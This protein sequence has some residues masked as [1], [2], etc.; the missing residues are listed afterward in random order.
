MDKRATQMRK[1]VV[2]GNGMGG[3]AAVEAILKRD[4]NFSITV[5]GGERQPYYNR[6]LLSEVLSGQADLD[7]IIVHPL[8]WYADHGIDFRQGVS[9]ASI[10]PEGKTVRDQ[11]GNVIDYDALLLATGSRPAMPPIKGLQKK[12]V[13]TFWTV[14]DTHRIISAVCREREAV[15]I[16]G[17]L[18]G[19]EA[20][21]ALI[22][23][24]VSVT[25]VHLTD[26]LMDR[27]LDSAAAS[28]LKKQI[29]QL[30]IR[31]LLE[32]TAE[33][34]VGEGCV[35]G[36]RLRERGETI[37]TGMVLMTTGTRPNTRL[38]EAAGLRVNEG[39]VVDDRMET[40]AS[41]IYAIGDAI[42]HRGK[43][44][45]LVAP[46][47]E[48]AQVLSDVL[49]GGD[50]TR[51]EGS[52]CATILKVAGI[53]LSS[54]GEI[55]RE[56]GGEALAVLDTEK[57]IYKKAVIRQNRLRGYI[58]LGDQKEGPRLFNLMTKGEDIASIRDRLFDLI[59]NV[60]G[61]AESGKAAPA[62]SAAA[63]LSDDD[64]V[65]NCNNVSK[66]TIASAIRE[67]KLKTR[68]AVARCTE[69]T[70]G[71]GSCVDWI[72]ALLL[73]IDSPQ[74]PDLPVAAVKRAKAGALKT[75]D[76]N[77]IKEE[78]LGL[79]FAD[80]RE[81]GALAVSPDDQYRLKT[82]GICVQ[83]HAGYSMVR[84]RIPGGRLAPHQVGP[85]A[86]LAA[87]HGRG[88]IHLTVRQ[89]VEL[90]W[91]RVEEACDIFERLRAIGLTTRSACGHTLRN[92]TACSHGAIA[93]D[94]IVDVQPIAKHMSDYF[95]ARSD[96]INPKMPN[97]LNLFFSG[98][99]GCAADA[100]INDIGFAAVRQEN[101]SGQLAVGFD[102]WVGG[103]LGAHPKLGYKL[104]SCLSLSDI[105]PACRAIFELH[106]QY[107]NR[108]KARSRLKFLIEQWGI[109]RFAERFDRLFLQKKGEEA[110]GIL[111]LQAAMEKQV[112]PE[113]FRR[114]SAALG[115]SPSRD[116]PAGA[117]RQR[118]RGF[119]R[120]TVAIPL[121]D[122]PSEKFLAL[123]RLAAQFGDGRLHLTKD[124]DIELHWVPV[125]KIGRLI[126]HLEGMG[127][128]LKGR[129]REANVISCVGIEFCTLAVT[130]AQ[131]AASDLLN[132]YKPADPEKQALFGSISIH[133]SGCPNSCAT[134][135]AADIGLAGTMLPVGDA[136]RFS[137]QLFVGGRVEGKT[138]LG[139]MV[140][141]GI[142]EEMVIPTVDALLDVV[143]AERLEG[144]SFHDVVWRLGPK[145]LGAVLEEQIAPFV[146][147]RLEGIEM[148]PELLE[149]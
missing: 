20:A 19:L 144:E 56:N 96:L 149:V 93:S 43:T 74:T 98:C 129:S 13:F 122:M 92:V 76:L 42:E 90:H 86:E 40:S 10:D 47:K 125:G 94:G 139:E 8:D 23:Y 126:K 79:D 111:P 88:R 106:I 115:A 55:L 137:Y 35:Q 140:R 48:Q 41:G 108:N 100:K 24:G 148:T 60:G 136:R 99:E 17:G 3:I 109:D 58:L 62:V 141:K 12:G 113:W 51:Y 72:D 30:G 146:P 82:Y 44:Y 57:G 27:Q 28:L 46:L 147:D 22:N 83:K 54:A 128:Y 87:V 131:G 116:L 103:S 89:S 130:H 84:I 124:Q 102:L 145:K 97:R 105:L 15:V 77:K 127:F 121:G 117:L 38:A 32:T 50:R 134:H 110:E 16:G 26:R 59:G 123:G 69:A 21:R 34:I 14:K 95:I 101:P 31:V 104:R 75:L 36:V 68:E 5:F 67:K 39:I 118:Q 25:V 133:I 70:T 64:I 132:R 29:E 143:L 37:S 81:R 142:T 11:S 18:L 61:P 78:G 53:Q 85:L 2:V 63:S 65:C 120:L 66:G 91:V 138:R 1:L 135:Q 52:E 49:A 114:W 33:E 9:I 45:G 71:C 112:R 107:G 80:I 73:D 119:A 7:R 6:I 4:V